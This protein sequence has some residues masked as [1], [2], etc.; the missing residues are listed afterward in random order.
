MTK[1]RHAEN[2]ARGV[3][4]QTEKMVARAAAH[5]FDGDPLTATRMLRATE[6]YANL[7]NRLNSWRRAEMSQ[8][9]VH[10][11]AQR[12]SRRRAAD[13]DARE[14]LVQ[15]S[16]ERVRSEREQLKQLEATLN[17]TYVAMREMPPRKD[18]GPPPA[19]GGETD[20]G[21]API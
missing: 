3:L 17:A 20:P 4:T 8:H 9:Q 6:L 10:H 5:L 12:E 21:V 7:G 2:L 18:D 16:E 11:D 19:T 13:L 15:L 1:N 14:A